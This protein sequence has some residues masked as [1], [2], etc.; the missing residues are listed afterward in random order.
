M[1]D[2]NEDIAESMSKNCTLI[3]LSLGGNRID[4]QLLDKIEEELTNN[5]GINDLILPMIRDGENSFTGHKL[6]LSGK[7]ISNL[8]FLAKFVRENPQITG[9]NVEMDDF[10]KKEVQ[11][12]AEALKGNKS[13]LKSLLA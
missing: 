11:K 5:R 13:K 10:H 3:V 12:V 7:G 6:S 1:T 9:V 2:Y 8:D 4:E